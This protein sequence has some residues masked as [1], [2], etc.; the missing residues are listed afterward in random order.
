MNMFRQI[1]LVTLMNIRSIP[2]RLAS[3]CVVVVGIAGVVGV[4]VSV[5][6]MSTSLTETMSNTGSADRLL[7][8]R[9]GANFESASF[10]PA[11]VVQTILNTPGIARTDEGEIVASR[12]M[13]TAVNLA[14]KSD[15]STAGL[16]VR[17]ISELG[18]RVRRE[19]KLIEGDLFRSGLREVIVGRAAQAEFRGLE[20]GDEVGLHDSSWKVVGVFESGDIHESG[21]FTD[22]TTLLSA[23]Q[24]TSVNT[25]VVVLDSGT[26]FDEFEAALT[27]NTTLSVDIVLETEYYQRASESITAVLFFVTNIVGA[28][29]ALGA[30]FGALNT[31]YSAV[32]ARGA[33]IATLRAMGFGASGVVA[34]VL[35]EALL[36]SL[37]GALVGAA[38]SWLFFSGNMISVGGTLSSVVFELQV[39]PQLLGVGIVWA[40]AVGFLGGL[41]P[42]I[43]AV[44]IPIASALRQL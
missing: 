31:M 41:F 36:L 34:S 29:M 18:F 12:E 27:D 28:I 25:V 14:R 40:C 44:R 42:A 15:G 20:I 21:L 3:S 37:V 30:L 2:Q 4:L 22:T 35:A 8:M 9:D 43:R 17:G 13:V 38:F 33:E 7:V 26:Q 1:G 32:S 24:R 11:D 5:L 10:L 19:I 16:S 6:A 23:Y 39:T